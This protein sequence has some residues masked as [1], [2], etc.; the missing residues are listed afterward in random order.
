MT[1]EKDAEMRCLYA[2]APYNDV[3]IV[4]QMRKERRRIAVKRRL[5]ILSFLVALAVTCAGAWVAGSANVPTQTIC[6]IALIVCLVLGVCL[7]VVQAI[8]K[9]QTASGKTVNDLSCAST[10]VCTSNELRDL[11]DDVCYKPVVYLYPDKETRCNVKVELQGALTCT[12]PAYGADGWCGFVAAPDGTLTFPDGRKYYCLYWE[13]TTPTHW[14]FSK[15]YC[16]KGADTADFLAE[17]LAKIGLSFREAN[18]FIIYW[19]LH[20][21]DNPYNV[22]AFQ[23]ERYA[24]SARLEIKPQPDSILR[25]FMAWKASDSPVDIAAPDITPFE[26]KGFTVVEWGGTEVEDE[27][28]S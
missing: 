28:I 1:M 18:E 13:G 12:Y 14:D 3:A 5:R 20:M 17:V 8:W 6:L 23:R 21:Q 22:I 19:L 2:A 24:E 25:V 4:K 26:R 16:V 27:I 9:R 10:R 15:G 11:R 7:V